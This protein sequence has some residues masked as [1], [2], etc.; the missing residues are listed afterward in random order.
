MDPSNGIE[1]D[2]ND[3]KTILRYG[4]GRWVSADQAMYSEI[5]KFCQFESQASVFA[6]AHLY[7]AVGDF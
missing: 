2:Q 5:L 4:C 7:T 1:V 6:F 3:A